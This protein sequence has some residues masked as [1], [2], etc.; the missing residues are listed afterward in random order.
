MYATDVYTRKREVISLMHRT[1][2]I[3]QRY[4]EQSPHNEVGRRVKTAWDTYQ[5]RISPSQ[6]ASYDASRLDVLHDAIKLHQKAVSLMA[7]SPIH[8]PVAEQQD[9]TVRYIAWYVSCLFNISEAGRDASLCHWIHAHMLYLQG[10]TQAIRSRQMGKLSYIMC[11]LRNMNQ[12]LESETFREYRTYVCYSDNEIQQ[13]HQEVRSLLEKLR[14]YIHPKTTVNDDDLLDAYV[15]NAIDVLDHDLTPETIH[16]GYHHI[17]QRFSQMTENL[18]RELSHSNLISHYFGPID[19][20]NTSGI[21][22]FC[23]RTRC[24]RIDLTCVTIPPMPSSG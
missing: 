1:D 7:E 13:C 15:A 22:D 21:H 3:V 14:A 24:T 8:L 4:I 10:Q 17:V 5:R 12:F 19:G 20:Y 6:L 2:A 16:R 18:R 23:N 11:N 9:E